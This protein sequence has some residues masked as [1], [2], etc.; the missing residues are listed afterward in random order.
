M[1]ITKYRQ[2]VL[3]FSKIKE[4]IGKD[5]ISVRIKKVIKNRIGYIIACSIMTIPIIVLSLPII[6]Y[7]IIARDLSEEISKKE[8]LKV[9]KEADFISFAHVD[10]LNSILEKSSINMKFCEESIKDKIDTM[11]YDNENKFSFYFTKSVKDN[12][13]NVRIYEIIESLGEGNFGQVK[14]VK[15]IFN[16]SIFAMKIYFNS[17]GYEKEIEINQLISQKKAVHEHLGKSYL[18]KDNQLNINKSKIPVLLMDC[19]GSSFSKQFIN[20]DD[21]SLI[22]LRF[23]ITESLNILKE[24]E[25]LEI[26]HCDWHL[27]NILIDKNKLRLVDFGCAKKFS[28][29]EESPPNAMDIR[30]FLSST[31]YYIICLKNKEFDFINCIESSII[32][33]KFSDTFVNINNN[34][35][36]SISVVKNKLHNE[37]KVNQELIGIMDSIDFIEKSMKLL[38]SA[39]REIK[40]HDNNSNVSIL[41]QISEYWNALLI[42]N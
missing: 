24:L 26:T 36:T 11:H 25:K 3:S 21:F 4:I 14:K 40:K 31:L 28:N 32:G 37:V 9:K 33:Y 29:I 12:N 7:L 41:K 42:V 27:E 34:L 16:K 23:L 5:E 30:R 38:N 20:D 35:E 1:Q 19:Y 6:L 8:Y 10:E 18:T 15:N 17:D 39:S 22:N 2:E 13:Y